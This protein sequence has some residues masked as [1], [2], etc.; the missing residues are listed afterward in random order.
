VPN[1]A[2]RW[3]PSAERA[4]AAGLPASA[5]GSRSRG[6]AKHAED[7]ADSGGAGETVVW[8]L[9]DEKLVPLKVRTVLSDGART[10]VVADDLKEGAQ[11]VIGEQITTN[12]NDTSDP[13][14]PKV[15]GS[16]RSSQ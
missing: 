13:F 2:L 16:R 6:A 12:N 9:Q 14:S 7:E 11:V 8:L 4:A 3:Q 10:E 5:A 15:F 1:A